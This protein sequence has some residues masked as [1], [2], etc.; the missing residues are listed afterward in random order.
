MTIAVN[1]HPDLMDSTD[2]ASAIND[3]SICLRRAAERLTKP[4]AWTQG[5]AA[6]NAR[7]LPVGFNDPSAV[8]WC[9]AGAVRKETIDYPPAVG[10]IA[11]RAVDKAIDGANA[12]H[13]NDRC[14]SPVQAAS[15]IRIAAA[16][17]EPD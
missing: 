9:L 16:S 6:R 13:W 5:A 4:H 12:A 2:R 1:L 8:R 7:G 11:A 14:T 3:A 17:L 10:I 15:A